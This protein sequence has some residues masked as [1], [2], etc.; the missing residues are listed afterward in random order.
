MAIVKEIDWKGA[1]TRVY[2]LLLCGRRSGPP[3][4]RTGSILLRRGRFRRYLNGQ[5]RKF[6]Y[7]SLYAHYCLESL[8]L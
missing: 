3:R 4:R 5:G 8:R 1:F 6:N 7:Q 2:P